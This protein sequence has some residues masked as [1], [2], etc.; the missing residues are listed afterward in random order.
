MN[1]AAPDSSQAHVAET[2][3]ERDDADPPLLS[4]EGPAEEEEEAEAD[5]PPALPTPTWARRRSRA[6][7]QWRGNCLFR[8]LIVLLFILLLV[9]ILADQMHSQDPNSGGNGR[10]P[11][12]THI[13]S[14][15]SSYAAGPGIP[16]Q[17]NNAAGRS[18]NNYAALLQRRLNANTANDN[19]K[20]ALTDL[21]VSGATLLNLISEP[22]DTGPQ[23]FAPQVRGVP[24]A[25]DLV[26]VL[27]GGNDIDY[28]GGLMRDA[29]ELPADLFE[30]MSMTA[31]QLDSADA[32]AQRY[33]R[34]LD[35]VHAAAP[36]ATVLVVEYLALLG[37]D[38]VP[39]VHAPFGEDRARYHRARAAM[40]NNGTRAARAGRE[41]WCHVVSVFDRTQ[42][43]GI[44]A[45]EPWVTDYLGVSDVTHVP[46]H[47]NAAG[48]KGWKG[49][50]TR[51][52]SSWS[53]WMMMVGSCDDTYRGLR[54]W[55][56]SA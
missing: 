20:V 46:Y 4:Q 25:A 16:P 5:N 50:F 38:F 55:I 29:L 12:I 44:G 56:C 35:A 23:V 22:Q 24:S 45:A 39:G 49:L 3:L 40:L 26:L 19:G 42:G 10:P 2:H 27:G 7:N 18:G 9:I 36:R 51:S 47:P 31:D 6:Q 21:S 13:A 11:K 52:L 54:G 30:G 28:I 53:W 32:L 43:H 14:L 15:G 48:M 8:L 37:A 34:V 41:G 17:R 33:G 1:Q